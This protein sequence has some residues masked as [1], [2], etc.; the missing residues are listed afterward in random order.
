MSESL[1]SG[2]E[3]PQA[4]EAERA[5][6]SSLMQQP[7]FIDEMADLPG[8]AFHHPAHG[9]MWEALLEMNNATVP[10]DLVTVTQWLG[11]RKRLEQAGGAAGVADVWTTVPTGANRK[12]YAEIVREK[13][14]RRR[15][16]VAAHEISV[17][18]REESLSAEELLGSAEKAVLDLRGLTAG[19]GED[20]VQHCGHAVIKA[21][22]H[23]E[24]LHKSR[25]RVMGLPTGFVDWDRMTN[26]LKGGEMVIVAGRPSQ[27]KSVIGLDVAM[28][29]SL[30]AD[31]PTL[32]FSVEMPAWQLMTRAVMARS[33]VNLA[34]LHTGFFGKSD[35][36]RMS[37]AI[38]EIAAAKLYLD[39]TPGLSAAQ[40]RA[41]SRAAKA[42]YGIGLIVVDY[43]QFMTGSDKRSRDN[44]QM[45]V[46]EISRTIKNT[47]KELDIPVI[48]LAQLNRDSDDPNGTRKPKLSQLRESGSLEQDADQVL[49]I[50][51]LDRV[52]VKDG[53]AA[54]EDHHNT[55]LIMAK[56]RN[57]PV[58][59]IKL[60]FR[61]E[62]TTFESVTQKLYSN[63]EEERQ[64]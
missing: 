21:A 34:L 32:F 43:L 12:H 63:N 55:I 3:L 10:I 48:A 41:R 45:E 50:H 13:W 35:M 5:L 33:R 60:N 4:V 54:E 44:R 28:H 42:K 14:T 57:G 2:F 25:G 31:V 39:E 46:S 6:L 51:R 7:K 26:G 56:Q 24:Q 61:K 29:V 62:F 1:K 20:P 23:I 58:G 47:A 15:V 22:E 52:K 18:A 11:D 38:N 59:D 40:F 17:L 8:D 49:L 36:A 27:G 64:R 30:S 19:Q 37:G 9:V 53:E 16:I